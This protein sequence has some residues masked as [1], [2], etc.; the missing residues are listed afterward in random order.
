MENFKFDG[1]SKRLIDM[2]GMRFGKLVVIERAGSDKYHK[3]LWRCKCDCGA[4][5]IVLGGVLRRGDSR[6]CGCLVAETNY[7][8]GQY[9]SRLHK[10]WRGI[11]HRCKNPSASHYERYGGRGIV[12][13]SE[14]ENSFQAFYEWAM[15]NGYSDDLEIDRIDNDGNYEPSNCRWVTQHCH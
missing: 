9:K 1:R 12:I 3:P 4:E 2:V 6:S 5:T 11:K 7:R 10:T 13:C 15:S 14:W 8:H